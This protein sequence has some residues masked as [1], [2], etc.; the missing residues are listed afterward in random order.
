MFNSNGL[1]V[2][3]GYAGNK[4]CSVVEVFDTET[5][6]WSEVAPMPSPRDEHCTA[7][8]GDRIYV[9]GGWRIR[10]V[11]SIECDIFSYHT[12]Q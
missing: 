11:L 6:L 7:V 5:N 9:F 3:G 12:L 10:P 1:G 4:T 8:S 2:S